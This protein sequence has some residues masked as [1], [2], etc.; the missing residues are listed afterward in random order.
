MLVLNT[1]ISN[2][3]HVEMFAIIVHIRCHKA[4]RRCQSSG[5]LQLSS[6]MDGNTAPKVKIPLHFNDKFRPFYPLCI[7]YHE[8]TI[9]IWLKPFRPHSILIKIKLCMLLIIWVNGKIQRWSVCFF[10]L[11]PQNKIIFRHACFAS[12]IFKQNVND[13]VFSLNEIRKLTQL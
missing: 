11:N 8:R 1:L 2:I 5:I 4:N 13:T 7:K 3:W 6:C 12:V 10:S 9:V